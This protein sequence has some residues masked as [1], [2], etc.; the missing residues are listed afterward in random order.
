[1]KRCPHCSEEVLERATVCQRCRTSILAGPGA[2]TGAGRWRRLA[3]AGL[4]ATMALVLSGAAAVP[5]YRFWKSS[6]CQPE[7]WADWSLAESRQ[8]LS[9]D[10]V[11][12][13][14]TTGNLLK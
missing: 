9:P 10:Y 7:S 6:R 8:C 13:K 14:M 12:R 11:C 3:S 5:V 4:L 2:G 1:M